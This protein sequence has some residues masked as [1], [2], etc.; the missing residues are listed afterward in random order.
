MNEVQNIELVDAITLTCVECGQ[1]F[2]ICRSCWRG[3]KCCSK[4]CSE[5]LRLKKRRS[6]QK[7]YATSEKGL[8]NGRVR[9][10]RRYEKIK[11][12]KSSH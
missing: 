12:F 8:Q 3:Q 11:I 2:S 4:V 6:Y 10:A 9:Q 5:S 7:K 1:S